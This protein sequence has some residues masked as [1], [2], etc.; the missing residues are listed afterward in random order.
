MHRHDPDI[1]SFG[2]DSQK[3][4]EVSTQLLFHLSSLLHP[5][6]LGYAGLSPSLCP[7]VPLLWAHLIESDLGAKRVPFL[8]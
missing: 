4:E 8:L 5:D 7:P 3:G 1:P 6:I 2:S